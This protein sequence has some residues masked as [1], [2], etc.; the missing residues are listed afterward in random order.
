METLLRHRDINRQI[1]RASTALPQLTL[2][3][4]PAIVVASK[5]LISA[6]KKLPPQ[7]AGT[8]SN[9]GGEGR[10]RCEDNQPA[11]QPGLGTLFATPIVAPGNAVAANASPDPSQ[12]RSET[13]RL[14]SRGRKA[15]E[16]IRDYFRKPKE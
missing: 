10:Q 4:R 6:G 5:Q 11:R 7:G 1:S 9:K 12:T 15:R 2:A 13:E 16:D 8:E 3:S 14:M